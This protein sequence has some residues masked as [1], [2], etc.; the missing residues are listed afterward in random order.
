MGTFSK[1]FA[2]LG[3]VIA[4]PVDVINYLKHKAR[5]L[6]FSASMTPAAVAAA[7]K[8]LEIIEHEPERRDRLCSTSRSGCTT[9][10]ARWAST[11][12]VRSPRWCRW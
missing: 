3:G 11:P 8:S 7:L 6:I 10:S 5:P 9:A 12:G 1:C 4:G 2:S